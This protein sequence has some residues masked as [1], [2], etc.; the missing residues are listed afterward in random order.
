MPIHK[1]DKNTYIHIHTPTFNQHIYDNVA[2]F[3]FFWINY[4]KTLLIL[5]LFLLLTRSASDELQNSS[6][7][8]A[9]EARPSSSNNGPKSLTDGA[10]NSDANQVQVTA[11]GVSINGR[12]ED[13]SD[14][15]MERAL[16]QQA[17]LIG[18]Y[19]AEEKAQREWE[20]KYRESNSYTRVYIYRFQLIHIS[21]NSSSHIC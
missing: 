18:Q 14:K 12:R 5:H 16:N 20:E 19:E 2:L 15:D 6:A 4:F 1:P 8:C 3:F 9:S 21:H 17:Q 7:E 10:G 11:S 13:K